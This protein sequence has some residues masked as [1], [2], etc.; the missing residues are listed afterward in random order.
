M[1]C[2]LY[3]QGAVAPDNQTNDITMYASSDE[4]LSVNEESKLVCVCG[5]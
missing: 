2:C 1:N 4:V 5:D 3:V